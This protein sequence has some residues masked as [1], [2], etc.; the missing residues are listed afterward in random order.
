M[1]TK[2]DTNKLVAKLFK[3]VVES[4]SKCNKEYIESKSRKL[5]ELSLK[6][7]KNGI[8]ISADTLYYAASPAEDLV[9]DLIN[10]YGISINNANATLFKS[11]NEIES[12]SQEVFYFNQYLHYLTSLFNTGYR[13]NDGLSEID[14]QILDEVFKGEDMNNLKNIYESFVTIDLISEKTLANKVKNLL[15]SGI[16]LNSDL[17][18]ELIS[19]IKIYNISIDYNDVKNKEFMSYFYINKMAVPGDLSELLRAVWFKYLNSPILIKTEDI[20]SDLDMLSKTEANEITDMIKS[21]AEY[22]GLNKLASEIMRYKKQILIIRGRA[23][24]KQFYNKIFRLAK[25]VKTKKLPNNLSNITSTLDLDYIKSLDV[26]KTSIYQLVRAYNALINKSSIKDDDL[27]KA[28][29]LYRIRNGKVWMEDVTTRYNS[30][31]S[32]RALIIASY[33]KDLI[34]YKLKHLEGKSIYL[35]HDFA[36]PTSTKSF[37]GDAIPEFTVLDFPSSMKF[38]IYWNFDADLDMHAT[39]IDGIHTGWNGN[40]KSNNLIY[41]G[42][43]VE[44]NKDGYAAEFFRFNNNDTSDDDTYYLIES[45]PYSIF[46]NNGQASFVVAKNNKDTFGMVSPSDI[47]FNTKYDGTKSSSVA[48]VRKSADRLYVY[49]LNLNAFRLSR[50]TNIKDSVNIIKSLVN[51]TQNSL[52]IKDILKE[53]GANVI[54][55]K[56]VFEEF[57]NSGEILDYDLSLNSLTSDKIITLL[58]NE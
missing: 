33:I 9:E 42:D 15:Y 51:L 4:K 13:P 21:Y 29:K 58:E 45:R 17:I 12:I 11:F 23:S 46:K 36:I 38:G 7:F 56:L 41:S 37:I 25:K 22:H 48:L 53:I 5:N 30:K 1:K 20:L 8:I 18:D 26:D 55:D 31:K 50:V 6:A 43:V 44:L 28:K 57:V 19:L 24:D 32:E 34:I 49:L 47:V 2:K 54:D 16:A 14:L 10:V 35:P 39:S 40:Y 52:N 27:N 3:S